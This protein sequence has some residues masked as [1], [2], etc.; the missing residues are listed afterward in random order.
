MVERT[1]SVELSGA[2]AV[3]EYPRE[4]FIEVV[5]RYFQSVDNKD[6][7]GTVACFNDDAVLIVQTDHK[8]FEGK[9]AIHQMFSEFYKNSVEINHEVLNWVVEPAENKCATEQIYRGTLQDGSINDM[10]NC[11]FFDFKD[12]KC[13][14]VIIFMS[15]TNPLQ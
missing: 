7:E 1:K 12:G 14:R 11:N 3:A 15:G 13:Q 2:A 8:R 10:H 6:V 4:H 9:Q 5:T